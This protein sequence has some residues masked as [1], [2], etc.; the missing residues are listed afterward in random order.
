MAEFVGVLNDVICLS[1]IKKISIRY[2]NGTD[3]G[4]TSLHSLW[5]YYKDGS[6]DHFQTSNFDT[7]K[8]DYEVLKSALLNYG[9][10]DGG[11][12]NAVD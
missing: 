3:W 6:S 5:V 4:N 1:A 10:R 8:T 11:K 2:F 12:E 7:A 9:A